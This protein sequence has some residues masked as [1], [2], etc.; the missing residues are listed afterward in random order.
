MFM[1]SSLVAGDDSSFN[2]VRAGKAERQST[3]PADTTHSTR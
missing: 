2:G 1:S 3:E